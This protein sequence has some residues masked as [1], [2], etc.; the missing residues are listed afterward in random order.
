MAPAVHENDRPPALNGCEC[1]EALNAHAMNSVL[2]LIHAKPRLLDVNIPTGI[3]ILAPGLGLAYHDSQVLILRSA[4]SSPR[5]LV[6][7]YQAPNSTFPE[8][9]KAGEPDRSLRRAYCRILR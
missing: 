3:S 5:V 7:L 6:C 2:R 9:P 8:K 1:H 4:V